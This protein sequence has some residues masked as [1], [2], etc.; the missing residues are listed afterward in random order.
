MTSTH[1]SL[2]RCQYIPSFEVI[3]GCE[4]RPAGQVESIFDDYD[5]Y[6][7]NETLYSATLH[8]IICNG[9]IALDEPRDRSS[10]QYYSDCAHLR[11][12]ERNPISQKAGLSRLT[13]TLSRYPESLITFRRIH[14]ITM[15]FGPKVSEVSKTTSV[16]GG[17]LVLAGLISYYSKEN[18]YIRKSYC[19]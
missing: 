11:S 13:S 17:Y 8:R 10:S 14:H 9:L 5:Q 1:H 19:N 16:V 4:C 18:L 6:R 3:S 7:V 15:A 2:G 12:L